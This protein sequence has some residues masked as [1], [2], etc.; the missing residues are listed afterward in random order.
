M[1]V[2][3]LVHA[4]NTYKTRKGEIVHVKPATIM[5]SIEWGSQEQLPQF[6]KFYIGNATA[7]Q[8]A[9]YRARL[10][11]IMQYELMAENAQGRRYRLSLHARLHS[12]YGARLRNDIKNLLVRKW[13]ATIQSYD[14]ETNSAVVDIPN[15]DWAALQ[16]AVKDVGE[17]ML[18][19]R[20]Y[21]FNDAAISAAVAAG[22]YL[23]VTRQQAAAALMDRLIDG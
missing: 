2:E 1:P 7:E 15:T 12:T 4:V 13:G 16:A 3:L 22:G 17:D 6:V 10:R 23:A 20:R 19:H 11:T 21:R 5:G 8:V 14:P 9:Q 18:K